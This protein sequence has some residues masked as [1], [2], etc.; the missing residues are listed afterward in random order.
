MN[1]LSVIFAFF[2][3]SSPLFAQTS[4]VVSAWSYLN[5]NEL[6]K[7][8]QAIDGAILDEKTKI[9]SKTW[10]YRGNVYMAIYKDKG[11]QVQVSNPLQTALDSYTKAG[12]L[13]SK[14]DYTSQLKQVNF[15][16]AFYFFNEGIKPYQNSD[17]ETAYNDFA[18]SSKLFEQSKPAMVSSFSDTAMYYAGEAAVFAGKYSEAKMVFTTLINRKYGD[19]GVFQNYANALK[20]EKDTTTALSIIQQGRL[21]FPND[22]GLMND[23]M[24]IYLNRGQ[25]NDVISKLEDAIKANPNSAEYHFVLG[26]TYENIGDTAN[27]RKNYQS[28]IG[29]KT[30]YFDALYSMGAMYFNQAVEVNDS[31]NKTDDQK[32]YDKLLPVRDGL[33]AMALPW[34]E[35]CHTLNA[36]DKNTLLALKELYARTNQMD[37]MSAIKKELDSL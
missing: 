5:N 29:L 12:E 27:A 21:V 1:K 4:A 32:I 18:T 31:M 16:M 37:K 35:Q 2:I 24:N 8:Q 36:K 25:F 34:L 28:A 22:A 26:R 15:E 23:E 30:N 19:P 33:F 20:A 13:D 17:F 3:F 10:F 9:M 14:G 6:A 7:A 11:Q